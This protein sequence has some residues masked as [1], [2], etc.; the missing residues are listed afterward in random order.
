MLH[1]FVLQIGIDRSSNQCTSIIIRKDDQ[2][3]EISIPKQKD[4]T[5]ILY[6]KEDKFEGTLVIEGRVYHT[7]VSPRTDVTFLGKPLLQGNLI[8]P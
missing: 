5:M 1:T 7:S 6:Q 8:T 2:T 3:G 4:M